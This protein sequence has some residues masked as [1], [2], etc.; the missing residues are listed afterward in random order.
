LAHRSFDLGQE[1]GR[2]GRDGEDEQG[3]DR[4]E[5]T[6]RCHVRFSLEK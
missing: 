6:K 2:Q 1:T 4:G 3:G 5:A